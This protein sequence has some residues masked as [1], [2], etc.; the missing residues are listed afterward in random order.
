MW[1]TVM[2]HMVL[3]SHS[4]PSHPTYDPQQALLDSGGCLEIGRKVKLG[5][6]D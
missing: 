4:V 3:L 1:D 5:L 2:Y 6:K